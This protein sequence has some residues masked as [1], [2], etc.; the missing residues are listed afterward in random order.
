MDV[1]AFAEICE[2]EDGEFAAEV[3]AEFIQ[4]GEDAAVAFG[5]GP[6]E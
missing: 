5:I 1:N 4:A 3:F 6:I 2:E